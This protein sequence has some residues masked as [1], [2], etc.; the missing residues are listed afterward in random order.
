[1]AGSRIHPCMLWWCCRDG[2]V[3]R[4]GGG[5]WTGDWILRD[6]RAWSAGLLLGRQGCG[7]IG[8]WDERSVER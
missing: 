8:R 7:A 6:R 1:M 5:C 3:K 4:R 2:R